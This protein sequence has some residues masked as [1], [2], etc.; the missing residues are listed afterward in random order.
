MIKNKNFIHEVEKRLINSIGS[1][2]YFH[3]VRVMEEAV[4]LA[5][6]YKCDKE[7]A[8]IAGL[9]HDCGKFK[10]EDELLKKS[11]DFD[12]IQSGSYFTNTALI[13]G[14]LGAE[15]AKR[16]FHIEDRDILNAIQYHTTGRENMTLLEKIIYISDYIEPDR[17]FLGVDEIRKLAYENLDLAL[18]KA[19]D[20]TIKHI[21]DKGYYLHPDTINARNYLI[22]KIK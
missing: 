4:K 2:R 5:S 6:I 14:V 21:I 17:N 1:E 16:E 3:S 22:F 19:M 7:K 9:L 15:I 8:A 11:C 10:N 20:K 18:V 12:I 13:H